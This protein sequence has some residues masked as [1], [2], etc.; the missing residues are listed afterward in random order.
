MSEPGQLVLP[1]SAFA[2]E[3]PTLRPV[4]TTIEIAH[5]DERGAIRNVIQDIRFQHIGVIHSVAGALR[6]N[7]YHPDQDQYIYV[8]QGRM[9]ARAI[10]IVTEET[11]A[12]YVEEGQLE[13]MP[14]KWAHVYSF[15]LDTIFL[16]ITPKGRRALGE[17][18]EG[19]TVPF[20]V[21]EPP[22]PTE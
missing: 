3:P 15:P 14:P 2:P 17:E 22:E 1:E 19:V 21:W 4:V 18:I 16:N 8:V 5:M 12:Y 11:V 9:F 6:G 13:Y 10:H 7:H 20:K